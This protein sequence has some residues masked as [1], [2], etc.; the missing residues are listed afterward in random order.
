MNTDMHLILVKGEEKTE[1]I[2]SCLYEDGKWQITF[3]RG[4]TYS[5]NYLNVQ[6]LKTHHGKST[7]W[8]LLLLSGDYAGSIGGRPV[9]QLNLRH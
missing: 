2:S 5:Y 4:K 6:W 3:E 8:V 7:V 1:S 9:V